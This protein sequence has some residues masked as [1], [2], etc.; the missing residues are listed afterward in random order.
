MHYILLGLGLFIF[1]GLFILEAASPPLGAFSPCADEGALR[2]L[3]G[4]LP[5]VCWPLAEEG[6]FRAGDTGDAGDAGDAPLGIFEAGVLLAGVRGVAAP[7]DK[8]DDFAAAGGCGESVEGPE[9]DAAFEV[10]FFFFF[11]GSSV[12]LGRSMP[13]SESS[14]ECGE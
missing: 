3:R 8:G 4:A 11:F 12:Q 2:P 13:S 14:D 7:P 5:E 10:G 1:V 9:E 6:D